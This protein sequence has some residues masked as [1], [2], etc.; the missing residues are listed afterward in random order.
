[1]FFKKKPPKNYETDVSASVRK[2][3]QKFLY[4]QWGSDT[5]VKQK[6]GKERK[7]F[8]QY[9][10]DMAYAYGKAA[11]EGG[12][13]NNAMQE[14]NKKY[15]YPTNYSAPNF[16]GDIA[17][18]GLPKSYLKQG[19][20]VKRGVATRMYTRRTARGITQVRPSNKIITT[21]TLRPKNFGLRAKLGL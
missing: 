4:D 15:G 13:I 19:A 10:M 7:K 17:N 6:K 5:Y 18:F 16:L 9:N 8:K 2:K 11:H 12:N 14:I 21:R 20:P 3:N 1:M